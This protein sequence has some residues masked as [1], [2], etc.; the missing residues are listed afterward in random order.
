MYSLYNLLISASWQ[1]LKIAAFFKPKLKLFVEGRRGVLSFLRE[2]LGQ[3]DRVIWI[4]T[5]S[6]GEF[7][8]GLPVI[9]ALKESCSDY[10][11]LVTFFSPSGYEVK[12]NS[13]D[14]DLIT[15]L[16]IDVRSKVET[17]LDL[18]KPV[19]ALFVKYEIWPN[20]LNALSK[21]Q[22]PAVLIS[23]RFTPDQVFF[24]GYGGFMRQALRQFSHYFVQ[25]ERSVQLLE[26]LGITGVT[27][28]G[29]TRFDRVNEILERDNTLPFMDRFKGNDLC[30]VMGSTWPEDEALLFSFLPELPAGLRILIAPHDIKEGHLHS[31]RESLPAKTLF[32]SEL[33]EQDPSEFRILVLDTIGLLTKVYS[34]ADIAYVG[35]G[36]ATGLHNTL[37][38]AVFGIPV[39][40]GPDFKGFTEAED[41]VELGGI[42]VV[43]NPESFSIRILELVRNKRERNRLGKINAD[44]VASRTGATLKITAYLKDKMDL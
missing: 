34:Y 35:G 27:L 18:T 20:Y 15:Y 31:L 25:D 32:Y 14:V 21:R 4:H 22:I 40:T 23:G 38:P 6:L 9:K 36:F 7:E 44:F 24:K 29:D 8:Q 43:E 19:I 2:H 3:N 5:A 11:V 30:L 42:S 13:G 1:F 39:L 10:K 37:E 16:P 26:R 17:F 33:G 41:L 12:K 28:S